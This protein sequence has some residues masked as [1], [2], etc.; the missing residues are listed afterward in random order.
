MDDGWGRGDVG[1]S[2]RVGL[3]Y[4]KCEITGG[5]WQR[6]WREADESERC[7]RSRVNRTWSIV[8]C[9]TER[10]KGVK[11]GSQ[12]VILR[13]LCTIKNKAYARHALLHFPH[14]RLNLVRLIHT[15]PVLPYL[16]PEGQASRLLS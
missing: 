12:L 15:V 14:T 6:G 2:R 11:V 7:F 3:L 9:G 1:R 4:W 10:E 16:P 8:G 5:R 13:T